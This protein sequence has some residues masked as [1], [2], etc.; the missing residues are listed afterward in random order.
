M[1]LNPVYEPVEDSV[2][3]LLFAH[4]CANCFRT[5]GQARDH[6]LDALGRKL[7]FDHN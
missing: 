3:K 1:L 6:M 2:I 5:L 4:L 7:P